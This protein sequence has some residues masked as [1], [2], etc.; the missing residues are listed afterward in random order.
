MRPVAMLDLS[1]IIAIDAIRASVSAY[2]LIVA[3]FN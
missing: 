1:L 3:A 2:A